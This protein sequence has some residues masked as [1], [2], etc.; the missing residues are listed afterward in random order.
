M[1]NS[2]INEIIK[3]YGIRSVS[4]KTNIAIDTLEKLEAQEYDIFT[5]VQI[6]GFAKI[7]EREY[8]IDLSDFKNDIRQHFTHKGEDFKKPLVADNLLHA[9]EGSFLKVLF[10]LFIIA[11]FVGA[12][13]IYQKYFKHESS[14]IVP[15]SVESS[16]FDIEENKS[17]I[18]HK[19]ES[20]YSI[21][22]LESEKKNTPSVEANST[23][24]SSKE[25]NSS[26]ATEE[27]ATKIENNTTAATVETFDT[28]ETLSEEENT[29]IK[30]PLER[31]SI[32]LVPLKQLWIR[33]TNTKSHRYRTYPDQSE[34]V[35]LELSQNNWLMVVKKGSFVFIDNNVSKEYNS[36]T[37][38]Y[39]K[40]DKTTGV[41]QLS[42]EEYKKLGGYS[43]AL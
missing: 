27:N 23:I 21:K 2:S 31:S 33:V 18:D 22:V 14:V 34:H 10:Y 13:F 30:P 1:E 32:K 7:F 11:I 26:L 5:K 39:F 4:I 41:T 16:Y 9:K 42:Q 35:T 15:S 38:M 3:E 20:I 37:M 28:N 8:G 19:K 36:D 40:V 25:Q 29:T 12:W 43:A 24:K 17:Q 6:I